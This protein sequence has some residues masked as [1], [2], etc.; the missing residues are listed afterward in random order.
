VLDIWDALERYGIETT[1][2][3]VQAEREKVRE[4]R[5]QQ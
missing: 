5:M 2:R 1:E 3:N 4:A